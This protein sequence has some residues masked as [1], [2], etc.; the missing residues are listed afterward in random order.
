MNKDLFNFA[1]DIIDQYAKNESHAG[2]F[3]INL[4]N[5]YTKLYTFA[6]ISRLSCQVSNVL[7]QYGFSKGDKIFMM[8]PNIPEWWIAMIGLQRAGVI[9]APATTQLVAKGIKQRFET[10]DFKA[11]LTISEFCDKFSQ[12]KNEYPDLQCF[13]IGD[14]IPEGWI[15]WNES[16]T[17]CDDKFEPITSYASDPALLYFTSGTT[18][19]PNLNIS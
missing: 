17:K 6:E 16:V 12:V 2:L 1:I 18:G 4:T 15:N 14:V 3:E 11:V 5:N 19:L 9:P 10:T 7:K 13:A 8:L